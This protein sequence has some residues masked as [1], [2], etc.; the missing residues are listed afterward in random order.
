M[1]SQTRSFSTLVGALLIALT[2]PGCVSIS[3]TDTMPEKIKKSFDKIDLEEGV[4]LEFTPSPDAEKINVDLGAVDYSLNRL[5][6]GMLTEFAR[7]KFTNINPDS[8]NELSVR[9]NYLNPEERSYMGSSQLHRLDMAVS[10]RVKNGDKA[11]RRE[12]TIYREADMDGYSIRTE[13]IYGM[14]IDLI[15]AI[16]RYSDRQFA[17]SS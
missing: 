4:S 9:I 13:E 3:V 11:A 6:D 14:L 10:V 7:T 5:F 2:L 1:L 17:S 15:T 16:D 8:E 12:F